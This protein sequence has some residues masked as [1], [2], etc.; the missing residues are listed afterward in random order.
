MKHKSLIL[1]LICFAF[2]PGIWLGG[3]F[4]KSATVSAQV[5]PP[6]EEIEILST[7]SIVMNVTV[8]GANVGAQGGYTV[9]RVTLLPGDMVTIDPTGGTVDFN[10][11]GICTGSAYD[12]S[13]GG[14]PRS[15]IYQ[16]SCWDEDLNYCQINQN[17][18]LPAQNHAGL[19]RPS[20][21]GIGSIKWL[22]NNNDAFTYTG[23]TARDLRLGVNDAACPSSPNGG[24]FNVK[25]TIKRP[26]VQTLNVVVRGTN[27]ASAEV[28]G[29]PL[30]AGDQVVIDNISGTVDFL[31][32]AVAVGCPHVVNAN[33]L[34][35]E[36]FENPQ[37]QLLCDYQLDNP[38][39]PMTG[40]SHGHAGLYMKR[41][42]TRTFIGRNG[43]SFTALGAE[44]LRFGV[45]DV[46]G[47]N[48]SGQFNARVTITHPS[49]KQNVV[50]EA[51]SIAG[52]EEFVANLQ[53]GDDVLITNVT[54]TVTFE[55][56]L[57]SCVN[58]GLIYTVNAGGLNRGVYETPG[59][60]PCY[61]NDRTV[62]ADPLTA[63]A[64]GHAGLFMKR[65]GSRF[66]IGTNGA[67]F[68]A[69][70]AQSLWLGIND[71][72]AA[73]NSGRFRADVFITR[74]GAFRFSAATYAVDESGASAVV[75]VT[76]TVSTGAASVNYAT[77]NGTA[78]AG[79]D[80]TARSG[81]LYFADGETTKSFSIPIINDAADEPNETVNLT[82]SN[83][84]G[85]SILV[86]PFTAVLTIDD[87]DAAGNN[88]AF[89]SQMVPSQ[90]SAGQSYTVSVT[91]RNTGG[92]TW[93]PGIYKLG[94]QN[95]RDNWTW[96]TN[97]IQLENP[98]APNET[99][100]FVFIVTAPAAPGTYNFQWKMVQEGVQWFGA[101]APNV[102]VSVR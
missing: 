39:D 54:G 100:T 9:P 71:S 89:V 20:Q 69:T 102:I 85:G 38:A 30:A 86:K 57:Q 34:A 47:N 80:Y 1:A 50:V 62:G 70:A 24:A 28:F 65:G 79:Q 6:P 76:R 66:F 88:S 46:R 42:T 64:H 44:T 7:Q 2:V 26:Q 92:T 75:N 99:E 97:R 32:D 3:I 72:Y 52:N 93:T 98:V 84:V 87:N 95:P 14:K 36:L 10:T 33:G 74:A 22:G 45:N 17:D 59:N 19:F 68:T 13:P 16:G 41:N 12:A 15:E 48:N 63:P 73:N 40:P 67:S 37:N 18:P 53:P 4:D 78:L 91:M 55:T 8:S 23:T 77:S 35:R 21:P 43:A 58:S 96:G 49:S 56:P 25:V 51:D 83:P 94:S 29:A 5:A 11:S 61:G 90:M 101:T 81:V 60:L 31:T 27:T 82:L